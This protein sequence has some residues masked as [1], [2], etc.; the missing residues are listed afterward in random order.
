MNHLND[1]QLLLLAYGELPAPDAAAADAHVAAC[2][3]CRAQLTRLERPRVALDVAMP[4][5]PRRAARWIIAALAAAVF[6]AVLITSAPPRRK[7]GEGWQPPSVWSATAG[8]VAGGKAMVEI[9]AQLT[10][11]EQERPYGLPN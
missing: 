11:L 3:V 6:A 4:R 5:T 7:A 2:P 9:D 1:D 10:R 8:Y